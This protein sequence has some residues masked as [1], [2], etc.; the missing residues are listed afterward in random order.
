MAKVEAQATYNASR[1]FPLDALRGL[2][3][4]LMALDHAN[5][6]VAQKHLP[7]EFWGGVFPAYP[8]PLAFLTRFVTHLCA[9]GFF[10]LMGAGM[11]LFANSRLKHGWSNLAITGHFLLRGGLL[12]A[13]QLLVINRAWE[14][15][16]GRWGLQI[17]IGVL[18]ALGAAMMLAGLIWWLDPRALLALT[19]ALLLGTEL[20]AP[21][22]GQWQ[23]PFSLLTQ[24]LLV[25]GGSLDFWVNYPV[26]PWLE[27]VI[28]GLA[29]GCWLVSDPRQ[30]FRRGLWLGGAFLLAFVLIRL[31]DGF[32][33]VRPR[34]GDTW[35]DFLNV[36]K[37]PPS[38][39]F[40]LL[41]VGVNLILLALF[42]RVKE[43]LQR[44]FQPL[45]VYGRVPL[46]FYLSHLFVYALMGN[47]L[48]PQGTSLPI[49]YRYWLL[50]L[51][52]LYPLC[53]L[54]GRFKERQPP[55]S[56]ARFL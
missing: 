15:S 12:I 14:M 13:L 53:L 54:Y 23:Q 1:L 46:F 44:F 2:I 30:A 45:V 27:L 25:P 18:A 49:M 33:N 11:A 41:T 35:M 32:G 38:L 55:N 19:G 7:G 4:V 28:F 43:G 16:A 26:L 40:T 17:Y 36:V 22:P 6:F 39:T 8:N 42:A 48:T 21:E 56:A 5:H 37:Y 10:F 50:G 52:I 20:L 34:E 47:L 24:L 3:L 9:P 29:F 51:L 31:V